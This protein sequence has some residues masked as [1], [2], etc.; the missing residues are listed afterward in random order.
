MNALDGRADALDLVACERRI[1]RLA[2]T[3]DDLVAKALGTALTIVDALDD[4]A[5][6]CSHEEWDAIDHVRRSAGRVWHLLKARHR[7][8]LRAMRPGQ[9]TE[10]RSIAPTLPRMRRPRPRGA[11]SPAARRS[12]ACRTSSADPG[13][14]GDEPPGPPRRGA[15]RRARRCWR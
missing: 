12:R 6:D 1:E 14:G 3:P 5:S 15:A 11:G 7:R 8:R 9:P 2:R 4:R 10:P 13:P